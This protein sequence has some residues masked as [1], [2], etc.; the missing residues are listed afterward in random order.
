MY[1]GAAFG[2]GP[3]QRTIYT[4]WNY[5]LTYSLKVVSQT[6]PAKGMLGLTFRYFGDSFDQRTSLGLFSGLGFNLYSYPT[7]T[8][9]DLAISTTLGQWVKVK[10]VSKS[11]GY[12][13]YIDDSL[14]FEESDSPVALTNC[15]WEV[16]D[17]M[18][19]YLDDIS[20]IRT[21][22]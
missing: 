3:N 14:A 4:S 21:D 9:N 2:G 7:S 17:G 6:D 20:I 10:L 1:S 19:I 11:T 12:K 16:S 22:I 18:T 8:Q 5:E 15:T 13:L